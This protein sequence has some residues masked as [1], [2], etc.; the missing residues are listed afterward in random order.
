MTL[1]LNPPWTEAEID[2]LEKL[3]KAHWRWPA[4]AAHVSGIHGVERTPAAC[5]RRAMRL[6]ILDSARKGQ[7]HFAHNYD[8]DIAAFMGQD[9]TIS[10][11]VETIFQKHGVK[12]SA[13]YV[14]SRAKRQ[15]SVYPAWKQRKGKRI[16]DRVVR[17]NK[18]R[19][20][21]SDGLGRPPDPRSRKSR[22]RAMG[23]PERSFYTVREELRDMGVEHTEQDIIE[24]CKARRRA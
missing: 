2:A 22:L 23:V 8:D 11:M 4:I 21:R 15:E 13:T 1:H 17:S 20:R 14:R 6:S 3:Y 10:E 9:R 12:V 5:Q 19:V 18:T 24:I 7:Q 16:S